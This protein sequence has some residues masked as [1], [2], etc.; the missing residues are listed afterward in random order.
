MKSPLLDRAVV[1]TRPRRASR[2]LAGLFESRGARVLI[3]PAIRFEEP[4]DPA[5]LAAAFRNLRQYQWVVVTSANAVR[6]FRKYLPPVGDPV[7]WCAIG[8]ATATA[9]E[10]AGRRVDLVPDD[11]VGEAVVRALE[12]AGPLSGVS[13]LLPVAAGARDTIED[14]LRE[15]GATVDR[16][17]AYRTVE[18]LERPEV[19]RSALDGGGV[20]IVTLTSGSAARGLHAAL[21]SDLGRAHVAVIG[22]ETENVAASLGFDVSIRAETHTGRGLMEACERFYRER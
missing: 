9:L 6:W 4:E 5:P 21:G 7:K 1:I 15:R 3:H 13:V 19:L 12:E 10:R 20:D 8:P 14:G 11:H 16:I 2:A 17:D 22:P 18:E